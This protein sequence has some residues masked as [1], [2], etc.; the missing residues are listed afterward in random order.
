MSTPRFH[1]PAGRFSSDVQLLRSWQRTRFAAAGIGAAAAASAVVSVNGMLT[2]PAIPW[3]SLAFLAAGAVLTGLVLGSYVRAPIGAEA[4]LCDTR[5]PVIGLIGLA[6]ATS[7]GP[8]TLATHLFAG[9]APWVLAGVIQP[10]FALLALG[11]LAW[12][13]RDRLSLER[14]AMAPS[15]GDPAAACVS[16]RPL[17]PPARHRSG[18]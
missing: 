2:A 16:C 9:A 5:W 14:W 4:T 13:L 10:V 3:W 8:G 7:T 12:A 17:F 1:N 6:L 11:L 15:D 18:G